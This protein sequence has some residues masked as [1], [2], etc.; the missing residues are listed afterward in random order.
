MESMA[1]RLLPVLTA[2][3]VLRAG[4]FGSMATNTATESSDIDL[5]VELKNDKTLLDLIA[6]KL[7]L[8]QVA[9][10]KVDLVTYES[11]NPRIKERVLAQEKRLF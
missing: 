6:L 11:L 1:E 4:I 3:Q 10:R 9:K 7:D 8:E 5:L 2:H